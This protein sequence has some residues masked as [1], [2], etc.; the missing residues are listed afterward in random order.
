[1]V[2]A[3]AVAVV[4]V[5]SMVPPYGTTAWYLGHACPGAAPLNVE[6]LVFLALTTPELGLPWPSESPYA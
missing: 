4:V 2:I 6:G 1:E 3:A 5:R